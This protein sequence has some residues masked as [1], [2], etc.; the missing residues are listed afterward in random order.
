MENLRPPACPRHPKSTVWRDGTYGRPGRRQQR[1]KCLPDDR[2]EAHCFTETLPRQ[3]TQAG[4]CDECERHYGPGD[5]APAPRRHSFT[6]SE[7]A[8][9]L[10]R[11]GEGWT[12]RSVTRRVRESAGR[13]TRRDSSTAE[14]WVEAYAP[15]VLEPRLPAAG[16]VSCSSTTC[17][18]P[19]ARRTSFPVLRTGSPSVSSALWTTRA[20]APSL[21]PCG[22]T[23]TPQPGAGSSFSPA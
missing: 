2:A 11:L 20:A 18:S 3:R 14:D 5:G 17:L 21:Y 22:P 19:F 8:W 13:I 1:Y 6:A 10:V 9:A 7:I 12:Y 4:E 23:P 15:L 16:R